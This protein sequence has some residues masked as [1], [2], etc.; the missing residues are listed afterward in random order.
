MPAYKGFYKGAGHK[1][2]RVRKQALSK[3]YEGGWGKPCEQCRTGLNYNIRNGR[4]LSDDKCGWAYHKSEVHKVCYRG[5]LPWPAKGPKGGEKDTSK[6][7]D[8]TSGSCT[9]FADLATMPSSQKRREMWAEYVIATTMPMKVVA[10]R[11]FTFAMKKWQ[12]RLL[13]H[14]KKKSRSTETNCDTQKRC[15]CVACLVTKPMNAK[16]DACT[17]DDIP[18]LQP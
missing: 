2:S 13:N 9:R 12:V 7:C 16:G 10:S 17:C 11:K 18:S 1:A 8:S 3:Q 14:P 4:C 15:T 6:H 5:N